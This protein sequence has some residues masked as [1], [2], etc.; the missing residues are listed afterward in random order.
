[1]HSWPTPEDYNCLVKKF[2]EGNS[3]EYP[4]YF[5]QQT[6]HM[7]YE[8]EVC[9]NRIIPTREGLWHDF[10]NNFTWI[11]WP[12]LKWAIAQRSF[13][14]RSFPFF[15]K[16]TSRQNLLA[17]FDECGIIVCSDQEYIFEYIKQ[18]EWKKLFFHSK[19]LIKHC[20][21]MIIGHGLFEKA[22]SPFIGLTA[23][24][25]FLQV[26]KN[27]FSL[28]C[29][30]KSKYIDEEIA[31][32]ILSENFVDQPKSLHPFPFLGWPGWYHNQN[33][34]FYEN[35]NYFRAKRNGQ[36]QSVELAW[37]VGKNL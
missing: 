24:A 9:Q 29:L 10:F 34:S 22:L 18:H 1:M 20:Y 17:H 15:A 30:E 3:L 6:Q 19:D 13:S 8:R 11:I 27:F 33:E 28:S 37:L 25:I 14:E 23:K 36:E 7:E 5:T 16:R 32:Y 35:S 12:K 26:S 2:H 21:P 31:K 4:L